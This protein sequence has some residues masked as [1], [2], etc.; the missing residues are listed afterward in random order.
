V[1][2]RVSLKTATEICNGLMVRGVPEP[3]RLAHIRCG[4]LARKAKRG[5]GIC[6]S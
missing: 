1:G 6:A 5:K 4:E 2:H 3:L